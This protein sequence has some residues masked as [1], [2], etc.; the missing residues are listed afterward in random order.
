MEL[1]Q[2]KRLPIL[3]IPLPTAWTDIVDINNDGLNDVVELDMNREDNYRKKMMIGPN[4]YQAFLFYTNFWL[5]IQ[6]VRN[7]LQLNLAKG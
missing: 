1:L 7:T 4:N 6:Y 2:I 5:Q 3:N